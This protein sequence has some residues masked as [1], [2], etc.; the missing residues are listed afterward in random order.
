MKTI[1]IDSLFKIS[2]FFQEVK[3][4]FSVNKGKTREELFDG[5]KKGLKEEKFNT[6]EILQIEEGC[7]L[8]MKTF[9]YRSDVLSKQNISSVE[10]NWNP[11][12]SRILTPL[13]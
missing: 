1:I 11:S 7:E 8:L 3:T 2:Q 5:W 4:S 13:H 6:D 10:E 9:G 12:D